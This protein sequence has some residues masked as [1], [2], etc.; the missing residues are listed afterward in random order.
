MVCQLLQEQ[1]PDGFMRTLEIFDP[2]LVDYHTVAQLKD[3]FLLSNW[4]GNLGS[5][6]DQERFA[7]AGD[8]AELLSALVDWA[9][10]AFRLVCAS[11][12]WDT[13]SSGM[14]DDT[15]DYI[16]DDLI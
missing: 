3:D 13:K 15:N 9:R 4:D 1:G 6:K 11:N 14:A 2:N 5:P 12:Q 16:T 8:L 7:R 10:V